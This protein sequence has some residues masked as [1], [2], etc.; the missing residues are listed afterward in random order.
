MVTCTLSNA[1]WQQASKL[2]YPTEHTEHAT[3]AWSDCAILDY[4][5]F[6][7]LVIMRCGLDFVEHTT[8]VQKQ[9]KCA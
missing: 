1:H 5:I 3:I 8:E 6:N 7:I 4:I 9:Q 2:Y